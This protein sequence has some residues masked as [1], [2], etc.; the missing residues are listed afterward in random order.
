M[1]INTYIHQ[2][3]LYVLLLIITSACSDDKK[4]ENTAPEAPILYTSEDL[5]LNQDRITIPV[6]VE[7]RS[8]QITVTPSSKITWEAKITEGEDFVAITPKGIQKEKETVVITVAANEVLRERTARILISCS[9]SN[10]NKELIL[11]QE[12]AQENVEESSFAVLSDLHYGRRTGTEDATIK[13]PR[14][15]KMIMEKQP[16]VKNIFV[17]GDMT[18]GG[19]ES[20]YRGVL[21]LFNKNLPK[22]VNVYY[23]LGNHECYNQNAKQYLNDILAQPIHQYIEQGGYPFITLSVS[24]GSAKY[25]NTAVEFLKEHLKEAALNYPGKPIFVFSHSPSQEETAWG[26]W[27]TQNQLHETLSKYSQIIHF[28]G[29]SHFSIEDERSIKQD[30]F[31]WMNVGPGYYGTVSEL[32]VNDIYDERY[33]TSGENVTEGLIVDCNPNTDVSITRLDTKHNKE[34]KRPWVIKAP[35]DGSQFTY[36]DNR[37]SGSIPIFSQ[38]VTVKDVTDHSCI[39]VIPQATDDDLVAKYRVEI[40]K[41]SGSSDDTKTYQVYSNCFLREDMPP[42]IEW[43]I[44]G[45]T[46]NTKYIVRVKAVDSFGGES[47]T[48]ECTFT[49]SK[50]IIDPNAQ[51]IKADFIDVMFAP[52]GVGINVASSSLAAVLGYEDQKPEITYNSDLK[53]YVSRYNNDS[54]K[55]FKI[56]YKNNNDFKSKIKAG[57]TYEVYCK[58]NNTIRQCPFSG[59]QSAFLGLQMNETGTNKYYAMFYCTK[60]GYQRILY[61][62]I[63]TNLYYHYA[64]TFDGKTMSAY[65]NGKLIGSIEN[66]SGEVKISS[67]TGEQW[68]CIGGDTPAPSTNTTAQ[69]PFQGEI[70]FCRMH[71]K[72]ASRSEVYS[73]Y[74]QI[75]TRKSIS[76]FDDLKNKLSSLSG[77]NLTEGWSL[78]NNIATTENQITEFL[79]KV[80]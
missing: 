47:T 51:A 30:K 6:K 9:A 57:F 2:S 72:V 69:F 48:E 12:A 71:S 7:G 22:D 50:W 29:H 52:N 61:P 68:I 33:P 64:F 21:D 13:I 63:E 43:K 46:D 24:D 78:M 53:M 55:F 76:K 8:L 31:T 5:D 27:L 56:D 23:M 11:K 35:H 80:K 59:L 1:K 41:E 67:L 74:E 79:N 16:N 25:D 65:L 14:A 54:K 49:T 77:N 28:T 42:T 26:P 70:A 34:I 17:C 36:T 40:K 4:L 18:D 32:D 37:T 62:T 45:L 66:L 58:T 15:L 38:N 19:S 39:I 3:L 20:E 73:L 10:N 60:G 44:S 75:E